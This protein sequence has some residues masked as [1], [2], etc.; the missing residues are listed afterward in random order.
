MSRNNERVL[1]DTLMNDIRQLIAD[2]SIKHFE[3]IYYQIDTV[4][5]V[6]DNRDMLKEFVADD[7]QWFE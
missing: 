3:E 1:S 7:N 6:N 2:N 4:E 5:Y